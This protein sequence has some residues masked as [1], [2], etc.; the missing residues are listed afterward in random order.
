ME[1]F[2]QKVYDT[3]VQYGPQLI[4][5][6]LIFFI[7]IWAAKIITLLAKK[8]MGRSQLDPTLIGFIGHILSALLITI[9]VI[10]ALNQLGVQT[11]SLVAILGAAGL[12]VGLALQGSLSNF[13]S[14]VMLILFKPF[15][16]G[17]F[18]TAAGTMGTVKE[19]QIFNTILAHP[20]NR[21]VVVPNAQITGGII[22]NF[23]AYNWFTNT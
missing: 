12:A 5:A 8:S 7:G 4:A 16:A 21:K 6:L 23:S 17:D 9:V 1:D 13:A 15:S 10:A 18:I 11:T 22:S 20:D 19:V 2:A 3:A 14:G